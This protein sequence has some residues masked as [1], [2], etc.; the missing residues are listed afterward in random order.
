MTQR[1]LIVAQARGVRSAV[2]LHEARAQALDQRA[3]RLV[4]ELAPPCDL[5]QALERW[6]ALVDEA[7]QEWRAAQRGRQFLAALAGQ[8]GI[9]PA[10]LEQ[11]RP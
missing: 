1:G 10:E 5:R 11:V 3:Q 4:R 8:L 9:S 2:D 6:S 7:E